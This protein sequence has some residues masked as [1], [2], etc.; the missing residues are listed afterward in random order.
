LSAWASKLIEVINQ[1]ITCL[2]N[3]LTLLS[4]EQKF[5]VEND[6]DSL[7]RSLGDQGKVVRDAQKLENERIRLTD[8]LAK[9]L[10]IDQGKVNI[11]K[12]I[13]LVEESYSTKLRE[14]QSTLSSLYAKLE[15][16]RKKNEFL[17]KQSM[18]YVDKSMNIFLDLEGRELSYSASQQKNQKVHSDKVAAGMG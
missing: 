11:S 6:V 17:I 15:R 10:K 16:Q 9:E 7:R 1:E 13:E 2:E 14:L 5:L 12:L 3:F 18:K 4:E 8:S